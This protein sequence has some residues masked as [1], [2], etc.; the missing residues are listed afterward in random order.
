M[1]LTLAHHLLGKFT[2]AGKKLDANQQRSLVQAA[3]Q[4]KEKLLSNPDLESEPIVVLGR[5]SKLIGGKLKTELT[6]SGIESMF[7]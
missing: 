1:D 3:R 4:A 5:G 2:S 7:L 6:R